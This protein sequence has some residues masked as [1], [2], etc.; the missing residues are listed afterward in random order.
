MANFDTLRSQLRQA[1]QNVAASETELARL[2]DRWR[3][4][5]AAQQQ[6]ARGF[7]AGRSADVASLNAL[8]QE[9]DDLQ[10]GLATHQKQ[11]NDLQTTLAKLGSEFAVFT[12]PTT[13]IE[14]L[15]D[16]VPLLLFPVRLETRFKKLTENGVTK[17]ELWVRIYPDDCLVDS[18]DAALSET[19][20]RSAQ[21]YWQ[22]HWRAGGDEAGN[23]AAWRNLVKSHG[24]GR[25][26]WIE[27]TYKPLNLATAPAKNL[28]T[29]LIL[30]IPTETPLA[31]VEE[32]PVQ[33]FWRALWLADRSR[34]AEQAAIDQLVQSLGQARADVIRTEYRPFNLADNPPAGVKRSDVTPVVAQL[35]FPPE[36]PA[37]PQA[38]SQA[39]RVHL[40]PDRFVLMAFQG[41]AVLTV[42]GAPVQ[43]PLA[44][45]P[46]PD[47]PA[48]QQLRPDAAGGIKVP[49]ELKWLVDF[50]TAVSVGM[51][52]RVSLTAAQAAAGFDLLFVLGV[53]LESDADAAKK[54]L[55]TLFDHHHFSHG[56]FA[57]VPQ[58]T[59]TNNIE[60]QPAGYSSV[61][62]PDES[63]ARVFNTPAALPNSPDPLG[64]ADGCWLAEWLGIDPAILATVAH[65]TGREQ[66]YARAMNLALWP[67]TGQYFLRTMLHPLFSDETVDHAQWYFT[68]FVSGRGPIPALRIGRQPYGI[69][70]TTDFSKIGW[71]AS[72]MIAPARQPFLTRLY[73]LL[74][75]LDA[76]WGD[77]AAAVSHVGDSG[78]DP[79]QTLLDIL[80]LHP[81]SAEFHFRF[82]HTLTHLFNLNQYA[83]LGAALL[84]WP[85][86]T[87]YHDRLMAL[88]SQLGLAGG[89]SPELLN[90]FFL[91]RQG[92]LK[93]S[94]AGDPARSETE[95]IGPLGAGN[96]L[97]WL[98]EVSRTDFDVL[99]MQKGFP[100]DQPPKALLYLLLRHA[101][102]LGY[103][104]ATYRLFKLVRATHP[105]FLS[106][107]EMAELKR[108][109]AFVHLTKAPPPN[110]RPSESRWRPLY[111]RI[112][113]ISRG[114]GLLV[115]AHITRL[116]RTRDP[117]YAD[118]LPSL[119]FLD[120]QLQTLKLLASAPVAQLERALV[121]H[122]DCCSYRFDAWM[123]GL[124]QVQLTQ[125]RYGQIEGKY[126]VVRTGLYLGA[127]GWVENLRPKHQDLTPVDLPGDL[128]AVF[129]D[130][131]PVQRD[132]SNGG[133]VHAPSLNHAVTAA[134]LR[135]G[136]I[137][138]ATPANHQTLQVNLSSERVRLALSF[139]EGVG[140][141]QSL[142]ALLG[143]QLERGL[144]DRHDVA[145]LDALIYDLRKQFPLRAN[146]L[147][148][149]EAKDVPIEKLEARNVIDGLKLVEQIR[150]TG[151]SNYPF[152]LPV[153]T[154]RPV[155]LPDTL[156][157]L[158]AA[159]KEA[160]DA[161]V[162][163][164]LNIHDALS[165]IAL[166]EGVHQATQGNFERAAG[167]LEAFM[168]GQHP[169]EP[170]VVR[171]PT[172]G[173]T[174]THRVGLHFKPGLAAPAVNPTPRAI[175]EPAVNDWLASVLP[176]L[177]QVACTVT[178]A[179]PRDG[180]PQEQLVT[181]D[182]LQLQPL[183]VLQLV[184]LENV[185][186]MTEL[187]DRITLH[188]INT[189]KPRPD[190][191]LKITY[192]R[193]GDGRFGV[194]EI[195]PLARSLR[196]LVQKSR[197][198]QAADLVLQNEATQGQTETGSVDRARIADV[199][200]QLSAL[201]SDV[202]AFLAELQS[203]TD[204]AAANRDAVLAGIDDY[205]SRATDLLQ[206]AALFGVSQGGWGFALD[207]KRQQFASLL[208]QTKELVDR[209]GD[210]LTRFTNLMGQYAATP[211]SNIDQRFALL[212]EAEGEVSASLTP[213]PETPELLQP[214]VDAK[215]TAFAQKQATFA[216]LLQV[217][218]TDLAALRA[219]VSALLP[220]SAED[221]TP[222]DLTQWENAILSFARDLFG[223]VSVVATDLTR[224][225]TAAQMNLDQHDA[226]AD[227]VAN[228]KLLTQAAQ[229]LLGD[230]F[231]IVPEFSVSDAQADEWKNALGAAQSGELFNYLTGT[232]GTDFPV[233][234][235]LYGVARVRPAMHQWETVVMHTGA[236]GRPEPDLIPVQFPFQPDDRWLA[237]DYPPTYVIDRDRM[238]YTAHY[239]TPFAAGQPQ[240]GL[241]LDEWAEVVP[242][243]D[244][245]THVVTHETGISF[246]YDRP[247]NEAAQSWLLVTPAT[248]DGKWQ[249]SDVVGALQ[250]TLELAKRRAV[251]P[252]QIDAEPLAH[253][254]PAVLLAATATDISI[255][256][257]LAENNPDF[258][259]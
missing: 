234:E 147:T 78:S 34:A 236:F 152:G 175:A 145:E 33:Q 92:R 192:L 225:Q 10:A 109:P 191:L 203:L 238:L 132:A 214:S 122:V 232:L 224:R 46:D 248:W 66:S 90:H 220:T 61:E 45:G 205:L 131:S 140:Q 79:Q 91:F 124:A 240:C 68:Q 187:D 6:L 49:Q 40:L 50:D 170:S 185:Q 112:E 27:R 243:P 30:V 59:P 71:L 189:T 4:N 42:V 202:L 198:L 118:Q 99:R 115:E 239:A 206:R 247:N 254:L 74:Q 186:A 111:S 123:L 250:Q 105:T 69:L 207:W 28:P 245:T 114:D 41:S 255:S 100:G 127:Y 9:Q 72:A 60:G 171:T 15:T 35:V 82:A 252:Q 134:V 80:G 133:Y 161:E 76:L 135:N 178:W 149:T 223:V 37:K 22:D 233:D 160:V 120:R 156:P 174:L 39:P 194:N 169:P 75:R 228:V 155:L 211:A 256:T 182:V 17:D 36:A 244:P 197:P 2:R 47:A 235:W 184:Q 212:Q 14:K 128:A 221:A 193:P 172:Q 70:P 258:K 257:R 227:P 84:T 83:G 222:F 29:D 32:T 199:L 24:S 241:L 204:D 108:E 64:K 81:T 25:A 151:V 95:P 251:E 164:L 73:P 195:A 121:E 141:G 208:K 139:L 106:D 88:L 213:R 154:Q 246:H 158:T 138:R 5:Q 167:T 38:W 20:V 58:G 85:D 1:R 136:Y 129:A 146:Q 180:T 181:L 217:N 210:K 113:E 89:T 11:V 96:Y 13:G 201:R 86:L 97:V 176:P 144:H 107:A 137:S 54:D 215:G 253:F 31:T 18:F 19:E 159:Q 62:D 166:A 162:D 87:Q 55:E 237:L 44:V 53:R 126:A 16:D 8:R 148:S 67:G 173:I 229:A 119:A 94:L 200:A 216:A 231:R 93:G 117:A 52:F 143:Y 3:A 12:D 21:R 48:D 163:R 63:Y 23:R 218:T 102:L 110:T 249:W 26:E 7:D 196:S 219:E 142:G 57:L 101:I 230:D 130:E 56:G 165:D 150:A 51:G 242:S 190:A 177:D 179:D 125:M 103:H 188:V 98:A 183:D 77:L 168:Q 209:W 153:T 65:A 104:D 43:T 116:L 157:D 226:S 259:P